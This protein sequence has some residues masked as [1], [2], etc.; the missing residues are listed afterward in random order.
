MPPIVA[1]A[2]LGAGGSS[3][4]SGSGPMSGKPL[5]TLATTGEQEALRK[6]MAKPIVKVWNLSID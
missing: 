4:S 2:P 1:A 5:L 6:F 3:T